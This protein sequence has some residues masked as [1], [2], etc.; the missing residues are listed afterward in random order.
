MTTRLVD[1]RP[2]A[3]YD[4]GHLPGA[5]HLDS[6][7][8]LSTPTTDPSV[9]GRHPLPEIFHPRRIHGSNQPRIVDPLNCEIFGH[10]HAWGAALSAVAA[11]SSTRIFALRERGLPAISA[12]P[13]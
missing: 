8:T 3:A 13:G 9:G 4:A 11:F 12:S 7:A 1:C 6:E 5:V 10:D 2:R